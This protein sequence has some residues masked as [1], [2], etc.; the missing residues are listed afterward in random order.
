MT[1]KRLSD[2]AYL[3]AKAYA[4]YDG[5]DC[6]AGIPCEYLG[7]GMSSVFIYEARYYA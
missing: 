1:V 7:Y 2:M 5:H 6:S 3:L 4:E